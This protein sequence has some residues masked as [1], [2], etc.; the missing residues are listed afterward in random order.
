VSNDFHFA[1]IVGINRY[2]GIG[3]L[4]K[5]RKDALA[6][7][8]WLGRTDGGDV[9]P[10]NI[11]CITVTAQK[12]KSY[13]DPRQAHPQIVQVIDTFA[14][15]NA[16]LGDA[17]QNTPHG[18]RDSRLYVFASGHGIAP[19]RAFGAF[20]YANTRPDDGM[21][22]HTD[23]EDLLGW[24]RR[25]ILFREVLIFADCC[26]DKRPLAPPIPFNLGEPRRPYS[27]EEDISYLLAYGSAYGQK[28]FEPPKNDDGPYSYFTHALIEALRGGAA[29]PGGLISSQ[30]LGNYI[31]GWVAER[32]RDDGGQKPSVHHGGRPI[33]VRAP[34]GE[35]PKKRVWR[36]VALP[37]GFTGKVE[38]VRGM[39]HSTGQTWD[40]S[41]GPWQLR[42]DEGT[43]YIRPVSDR[44]QEMWPLLA[45]WED[46]DDVQL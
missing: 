37:A 29:G 32:T 34:L 19:S 1:V 13:K 41:K 44:S 35:L 43:Y 21:W 2:P 14:D 17:L 3:D 39:N 9:P 15:V 22:W 25:K 46:R 31:E 23:L 8:K 12:E 33:A 38:L 36:T 6:F 18:W 27:D 28:S 30:D 40:A 7:R 42:L 16:A 26:R 11:K 10:D 20:Q 24:Y 5:P 45:Y 4:R